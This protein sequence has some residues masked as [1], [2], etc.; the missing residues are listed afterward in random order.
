MINYERLKQIIEY[1]GESQNKLSN[2]F[3]I[4]QSVFVRYE[5]GKRT[6]PDDYKQQLYQIDIDLNWLLT[7]DGSMFVENGVNDSLSIERKYDVTIL[8]PMQI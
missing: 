6:I 5:L 1:F 3:G 8:I 4:N 2:R 7:G